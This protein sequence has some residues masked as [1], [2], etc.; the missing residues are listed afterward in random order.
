[1][2]ITMTPLRVS[3]L[4]GGTDYPEHF[5]QH[6]GATLATS[7]NKYTYVTVTRLTEF[8]DHRIRVSYSRT[9]LCKTVDEIQ[10]PAVRACLEFMNIDGGVEISVV[11]DLPAR[12]G[13]GSSSSFTVGLLHALHGFQG[14]VV[15]R[16]ELAAEAVH[17]ERNIIQERVGLQDQYACAIGGALHLQFSG[18]NRVNAC[19]LVI[20][21]TRAAAMES[22]L[23]MFYTGL[24][25]TAHEVLESQLQ[26]TS[27][28]Q[29]TPYLNH[30]TGLVSDG[31]DTLTSER[32]LSEFGQLLHEGWML[33]RQFSDAISNEFI[34]DA[35]GRAR[36]A[37][38]IGG[39][40]LGAGGGGFLLLYVE[41]E[42]Q[43]AVRAALAGMLE[44]NFNFDDQGSRLIFYKPDS[45]PALVHDADV[46]LKVA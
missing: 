6:G 45:Q 30:L 10:H 31:I 33:K 8:F 3:F 24:Q 44:V 29:I 36:R 35:Y 7:I 28:G 20:P 27:A 14:K 43:P 23:L 39:K 26:R 18:N 9:E 13:L 34:D 22:R 21:P 4:G 38:A 17:V 40:L 1:M 5:R 11:S 2:I 37:G 16:E 41:P 15:S 12:T 19:P 25:R 42:D 32:P 46:Q